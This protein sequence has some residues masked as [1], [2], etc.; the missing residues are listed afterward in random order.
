MPLQKCISLLSLVSLLLWVN[1]VVATEPEQFLC[2]PVADRVNYFFHDPDYPYI[3]EFQHDGIDF[4]SWAGTSI[5]ASA[6]GEVIAIKRPKTTDYAYIQILHK[7]GI[8]TVYGHISK[9]MVSKGDQVKKGQIIALT[10]GIPGSNGAGQYTTGEH[11]HFEVR[12]N[13]IQIQPKPYWK[14]PSKVCEEPA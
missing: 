11:L 13:D 12:L 1:P 5:H 2:R 9:A 4:G 10:G 8:S 3:D 6:K 14:Q 7:D